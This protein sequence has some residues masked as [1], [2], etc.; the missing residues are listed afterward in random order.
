[1][2]RLTP[3]PCPR[4]SRDLREAE[5]F[6]CVV[7]RRRIGAN[8]LHLML[9]QEGDLTA[10]RVLHSDCVGSCRTTPRILHA[11]F[12]PEC[13]VGWHDLYD[14]ALLLAADRLAAR[15]AVL[16]QAETELTP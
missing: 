10:D 14:H 16:Q 1:M 6:N 7:C 8:R 3:D 5:P 15:W 12:Y 13:P 9:G 4:Y 11:K 2:T